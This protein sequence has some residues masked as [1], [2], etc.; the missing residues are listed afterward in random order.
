MS[1]YFVDWNKIFIFA[2]M[3]NRH[4]LWSCVQGENL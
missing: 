3:K 4:L 1:N 2:V